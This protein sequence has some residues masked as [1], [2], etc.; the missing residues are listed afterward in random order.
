MRAKKSFTLSNLRPDPKRGFVYRTT[1]ASQHTVRLVPERTCESSESRKRFGSWY[2]AFLNI[3]SSL[4]TLGS[5]NFL[6]FVYK[7]ST[8]YFGC[9]YSPLCLWLQVL[10]YLFC[11]YPFWIL[12]FCL[13]A[14][15]QTVASFN[16][17]NFYYQFLLFR[18]PHFISWLTN[19][20]NFNSFILQ[21]NVCW[22]SH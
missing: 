9:P 12:I 6:E 7:A 16:K 22:N 5:D 15:L 4:L 8:H 2:S 21:V 3:L 13:N 1:T 14:L 11:N 20:I 10:S 17:V 19:P 18:C